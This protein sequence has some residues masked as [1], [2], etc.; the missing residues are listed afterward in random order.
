MIVIRDIFQIKF[1]SARGAVALWKE[2]LILNKKC[3]YDAKSM[4][5]LTDLV[6]PY[7]TLVFE[8]TF[9]S[10][11]DWERG[12]KMIT[13]SPD[14]RAW[15]EKVIAITQSGRREIFTLAAEE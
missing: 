8:S 6:G 3:G 7:Y 1:G 14:W 10:L 5:V 13:G 12:G 9:D 15:Y 4:R 11:S 2:G